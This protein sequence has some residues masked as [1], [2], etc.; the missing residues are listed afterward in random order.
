MRELTCINPRGVTTER[1]SRVAVHRC[2][3]SSPSPTR[4]SADSALGLGSDSCQRM[5][6]SLIEELNSTCSNNPGTELRLVYE[7]ADDPPPDVSSDLGITK[8]QAVRT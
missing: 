4:G 1:D 5:L 6:A 7:F 2:Q 3:A 8:N